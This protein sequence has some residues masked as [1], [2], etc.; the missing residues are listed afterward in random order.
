MA[1]IA[2]K[3]G[4]A[5]ALVVVTAI[6]IGIAFL[7]AGTAP[8]D[9]RRRSAAPPAVPVAVAA[10]GRQDLPVPIERP[11]LRGGV[12]YGDGT[13]AGRRAADAR[14]VPRGPVREARRG[15]RRDRSTPVP[16]AARTGAGAARSRPGAARQRSPRPDALSDVVE[17]GLDRPAERRSPGV[18][19]RATAGL[20]QGGRGGDSQRPPQSDLRAHHRADQRPRRSSAGR[21]GERRHREHDHRARRDHT[22]RA[23]RGRVHAAR[24][25]AAHC[26]AAYPRARRA[27]G[28][29]VRPC[30]Q[31]RTWP[32]DRW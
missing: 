30:W 31:R 11:R 4:W 5:V 21:S 29:R 22:A 2:F 16:G 24:G 20:A 28:R 1:S 8:A 14:A 6:I 18:D 27:A 9:T 17:P 26:V 13:S 15:A 23:Y 3:R 10:V 12:Q 19:R 7:S 32:A 25:R